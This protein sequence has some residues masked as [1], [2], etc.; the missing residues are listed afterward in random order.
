MNICLLSVSRFFWDVVHN[1]PE[2]TKRKLLQF[3]TGTDRVPVGGLS[4]IR[5]II[6]KNGPDSDR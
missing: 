2:E 6:V 1:F 4:K 5:M 3:I